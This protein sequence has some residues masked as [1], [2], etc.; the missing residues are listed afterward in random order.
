MP[1]QL[2]VI[3]GPSG[4]GKTTVAYQLLERRSSLTRL[5]TYTTRAPRPG[6]Q[7]GVDYH[8]VT[9]D[10]FKRMIEEGEL[11]EW[12]HVYDRYYGNRE[13]DLNRLLEEGQDVIMV[14]DVQGAKTIK[15][16]RSD[17]FIIFLEA[18]SPDILLARIERRSD[19][20][21]ADIEKRRAALPEEM[22]FAAESH[23]VVKNQ[24][25]MIEETVKAVEATMDTRA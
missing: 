5:I 11:F 10:E 9:E 25:G 23:A 21:P 15:T 16:K 19:G 1:G 4:V 22:A 12:A 20:K 14:V 2:Y 7:D 17:A 3:T 18:E 24:D 6:E 13:A 8:F